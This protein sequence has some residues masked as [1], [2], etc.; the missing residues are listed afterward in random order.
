MKITKELIGLHL[1]SEN[2]RLEQ[3]LSSQRTENFSRDLQAQ[4]AAKLAHIKEMTNLEAQQRAKRDREYYEKR[5]AQLESQANPAGLDTRYRLE[6]SRLKEQIQEVK[7][8][9]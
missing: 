4:D 8:E 9:L 2:E 5:I 6:L 7:D 3:E 1:I